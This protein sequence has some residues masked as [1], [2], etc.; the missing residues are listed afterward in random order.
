[1]PSFVIAASKLRFLNEGMS[2]QY[3]IK[4]NKTKQNKI[5]MNESGDF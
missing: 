1:M 4:K 5:V 3:N 2:L